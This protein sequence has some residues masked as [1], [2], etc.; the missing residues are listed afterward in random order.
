[1]QLR[2]SAGDEAVKQ[3]PPA[4]LQM[5]A[6]AQLVERGKPVKADSGRPSKRRYRVR[7]GFEPK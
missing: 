1:V 7:S 4:S 2:L 3:L 5:V 6:L